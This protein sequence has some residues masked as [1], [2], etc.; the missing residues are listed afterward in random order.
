MTVTDR[1]NDLMQ[2]MQHVLQYMQALRH[3]NSTLRLANQELTAR[4]DQAATALAQA[5]VAH[6]D[7][8]RNIPFQDVQDM[9]GADA[10][11]PEQ[12]KKLREEI[13]YYIAEIDKCIASLR[14]SEAL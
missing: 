7:S 12:S 13:E 8:G 2:K 6:S 14:Q 10:P 3:E 1:L 9:E 4:L 11:N 5:R